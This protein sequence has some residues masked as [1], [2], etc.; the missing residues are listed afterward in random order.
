M[1]ASR[2]ATVPARR[3]TFSRRVFNALNDTMK[4]CHEMQS[5]VDY[6]S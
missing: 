1:T 4:R 3:T 2:T 6:Y 5:A